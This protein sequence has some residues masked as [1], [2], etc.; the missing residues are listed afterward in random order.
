MYKATETF[1][2]MIRHIMHYGEEV[3]TDNKDGDVK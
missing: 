2:Y 3:G 1:I